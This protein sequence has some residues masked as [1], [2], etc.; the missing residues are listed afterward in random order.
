MSGSLG[1]PSSPFI[2]QATGDVAL[3]WRQ[4][5]INVFRRVNTLPTDAQASAP[6]VLTPISSPFTYTAPYNGTLFA[7][8]GGI[9]KMTVQRGSST[10]YAVGQFYGATPLRAHDVLTVRYLTA[11]ALVFFPG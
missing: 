8:G 1:F 2:D 9:E 11:P 10:P 6:V 5:L 3:V 7:A 4:W